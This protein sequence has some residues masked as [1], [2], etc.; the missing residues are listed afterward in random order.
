MFT[1]G[2]CGGV[3]LYE[4][5]LLKITEWGPVERATA[6]TGIFLRS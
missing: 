2:V 4:P 3:A 6:V 5:V 1:P